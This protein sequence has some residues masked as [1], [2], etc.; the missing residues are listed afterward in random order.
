DSRRILRVGDWLVSKD[1]SGQTDDLRRQR[2]RR[3]SS[4]MA[5]PSVKFFR[6]NAIAATAAN[7]MMQLAA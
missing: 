3:R 1:A 4:D 6:T 2:L 5:V 7:S